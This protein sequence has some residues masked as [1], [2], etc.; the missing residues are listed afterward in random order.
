MPIPAFPG[1]VRPVTRE[2]VRG[3]RDYTG[4]VRGREGTGVSSEESFC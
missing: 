1:Q 2:E 3:A 4:L